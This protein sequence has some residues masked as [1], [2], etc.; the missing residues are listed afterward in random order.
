MRSSVAGASAG[1]SGVSVAG[2]R[3]GGGGS[4]KPPNIA[5]KDDAVS[6]RDLFHSR[7]V[8]WAV[9]CWCFRSRAPDLGGEREPVRGGEGVVRRLMAAGGPMGKDGTALVVC[10][11]AVEYGKDGETCGE[12]WA[13]DDACRKRSARG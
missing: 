5:S 12:V 9:E 4:E 7:G 10:R 6:P 2:V 11:L 3:T 8:A 1:G 13:T